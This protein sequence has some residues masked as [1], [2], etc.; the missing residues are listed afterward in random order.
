M[1]LVGTFL[2]Q[3][4]KPFAKSEIIILNHLTEYHD[5]VINQ[6]CLVKN[7]P[8]N[9]KALFTLINDF[10]TESKTSN[11]LHDRLFIKEHDYAPPFL[12]FAWNIDYT[13]ETTTRNDLDNID[14]LGDSD[15]TLMYNGDTIKR[16]EV[17]VGEIYYYEK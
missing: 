3:Y 17:Y 16:M 9:S 13:Q 1:I 10:N 4:Y 15:I 8:R 5:E 14:F 11:G 2:Y 12:P 7:P 6:I